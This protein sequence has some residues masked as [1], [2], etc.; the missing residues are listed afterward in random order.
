V[1]RRFSLRSLIALLSHFK[2]LIII[3]VIAS[4]G[5]TVL[6]FM[7]FTQREVTR[8]MVDKGD[9][10][11]RNIMR[12]IM[13]NLEDHRIGLDF[14]RDYA[15]GRYEEQL[16]NLVAVVVSQIDFYHG[17]YEKGT[18]SEDQARN[19]ALLS[20]QNMRYGNNDYFFIYDHRNV[21]ISHADPGVRGKD[22]SGLTDTQGLPLFKTMW[23]TAREKG[24]AFDTVW[25]TRLGEKKP[26]TKLVYFYHY[27][28]WGWIVGTGLYID[29]IDRDVDKK[30]AEMI[31]VL[32]MIFDQVRIA[33]TGYFFLFNGQKK[34][35][36]HPQPAGQNGSSG[37]DA[38]PE[39]DYL[40]DLMAVASGTRGRMNH[41]GS[42]PSHTDAYRS[43]KYSHVQHFQPFDWYLASSLSEKEMRRPAQTII[44]RQALFVSAVF[45]C[46]MIGAIVLV[47]FVTRPLLK[48][49]RHAGQL[50]QADF[51]LSEE[52]TGKLLSIR[53]PA[54]IKNLAGVMWNMER[55]LV[56]Y[57]QN[58]KE[59]TAARERMESE[60]RIA[61]DIQMSMLPVH[62]TA[63]EGRKEIELAA[64]LEPAREIGGDLYDFFFIDKDRFCFLV[65]DVSDK[66]VPAALFMARS[67]A[68]L[69]NAVLKGSSTPEQIFSMAN[70]ELTEGNEML[71]F[72]TAFLGILNVRTGELIFSNAGHVPPI[73]LKASGECSLLHLPPGKP[74]GITKGAQFSVRSLHLD[75]GDGLLVFTDGITEAMN[76]ND[77]FFGDERLYSLVQALSPPKDMGTLKQAV[78][79]EVK[80][81]T[82]SRSQSDDITIL[83]LRFAG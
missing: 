75:R 74:L 12:V 27:P 66:G 6:M 20:V 76:G 26:V 28:K 52:T 34:M 42:E 37:M 63:L 47:S 33:D 45:I 46:A 25:W 15:R 59:T 17:L 38:A 53:F 73:L 83:C 40:G 31:D 14:F 69:R 21:A 68:I 35:L 41:L 7:A 48:L 30:R 62:E 55:R 43:G 61:R 13:L 29:D 23:K 11:A 79:K 71:M 72:I 44:R 50:E 24:E 32:K 70:G 2:V 18:L 1:S 5:I 8:S 80:D 9:E 81:F 3:M 16:R 64:S 54:E 77:A 78:L 82:G 51:S 22:M 65:G 60:L 57:L 19:A 67:K 58:L 39:K 56:E 49:A 4:L 10:E 36:V